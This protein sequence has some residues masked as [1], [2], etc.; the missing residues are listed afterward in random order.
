MVEATGLAPVTVCLQGSLAA[1]DMRPHKI[2]MARCP[3]AAPGEWSF[4]DSTALLAPTLPMYLCEKAAR[5]ELPLTA[6]VT[7]KEQTPL[8]R[9]TP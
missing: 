1:M 8:Q 6:F 9:V 2:E 3:G 4:G 7:N 5:A